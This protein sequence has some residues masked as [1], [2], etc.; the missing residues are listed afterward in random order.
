[1]GGVTMRQK[2]F[3]KVMLSP[4]PLQHSCAILLSSILIAR[5]TLSGHCKKCSCLTNPGQRFVVEAESAA[6]RLCILATHGEALIEGQCGESSPSRA[7]A[8]S[9]P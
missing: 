5:N 1:M 7:G 4:V 8:G 2:N 6:A 3:R 9:V